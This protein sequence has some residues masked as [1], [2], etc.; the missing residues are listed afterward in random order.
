M[1]PET[2]AAGKEYIV[3]GKPSLYNRRMNLV[4]PEIDDI[5]KAKELTSRLQPMYNTSEKMKNNY[6][7]SKAI[8]KMIGNLL[9]QL[10]KNIEETLPAWLL[11]KAGLIPLWEALHNIH[12]PDNPEILKKAEFRLKFEEFF[13]IQLNI[14]SNRSTRDHKYRGYVFATVGENLILFITGTCPSN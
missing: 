1:D 4:H 10:D 5:S 11:K 8:Q 12:Y 14:F 6:L 7:T 3:F 13:F 9:R 2:F